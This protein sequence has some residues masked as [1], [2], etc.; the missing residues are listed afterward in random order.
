MHDEIAKHE[1]FRTAPWALPEEELASLKKLLDK[2][3]PGDPVTSLLWLFDT[4]TLDET[5]DLAAS[6][7]RRAHAVKELYAVDGADAVIRLGFET[8]LPHFVVQAVDA[9]G[10]DDLA[11]ER[12][13]ELSF[14][15]DS[16]CS[17]TFGFAGVYR[18]RMGERRAEERLAKALTDG[19]ASTEIVARLLLAW[20]DEPAT[21]ATARHL[22]PA[23]VS[24]YWREKAPRYLNGS[25]RSLYR[26]ALMLLRFGRAAASLQSSFNRLAEIPTRLLFRML[27]GIVP[28]INSK[29]IAPDTMLTF[30]LEKPLETLDARPDASELQ[31][32][33]REY[34]Y[35]P[36]LEFGNRKL[37][38]HHIMASSAAFYHQ[39][40]RDV[41]RDDNEATVELDER[42]K[43]RARMSYSLLAGFSKLPGQSAAGID[44]KFLTSWID[45][46][47]RLG[48][49]TRRSEVT[50]NYIGR[51]LA[52][53]PLD[54][55]GGWPDLRRS[56]I[57]LSDLPPMKWKEACSSRGSTCA[58]ST[59]SRFSRVVLRNET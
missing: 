31:I 19:S 4:W 16:A 58:A 37:R 23:A 7:R 34:A 2:F 3:S 49:E 8:K 14:A 5:G 33:Q 13:F 59:V 39:V 1:R 53:A 38:L 18:N 32:A 21:W 9:A 25:R 57:K 10:L 43:A 51:V 54:T 28:E 6:D 27:D 20:P 12:L 45:D 50:D 55:D 35:L 44:L 24:S 42:T 26:S 15:R 29:A 11:V 48:A 52:H 30:Y 36:M 47:R 22:G 17:L 46:L 41:F 56:G 40:L